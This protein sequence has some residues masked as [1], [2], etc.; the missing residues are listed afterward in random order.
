MEST[1]CSKIRCIVRLRQ[2]L[3]RW[4]NKARM[5]SSSPSSSP[6]AGVPSD[7]PP[8]HVAVHV[9]RDFP[10]RYIVKATY[11][12]HPFF[13]K[14]LN[15]VEEEHGFSNTGPLVIP[16]AES[17]FLEIL[18]FIS[19][20]DSGKPVRFDEISPRNCHEGFRNNNDNS[21]IILYV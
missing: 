1:K 9:G 12:N 21:Y 13:K 17:V 15:Q 6:T 20:S 2:M 16:C 8:G 3:R 7:V 5:S 11:L 19:R 10:R 14:L 18:R 4:R